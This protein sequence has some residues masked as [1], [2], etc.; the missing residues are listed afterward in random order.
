MFDILCV[1][2]RTLCEGEF[3]ARIEQIA[4]AGVKG[5]ILRDKNMQDLLFVVKK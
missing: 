3:L 5:I 1:T 4:R 2:D